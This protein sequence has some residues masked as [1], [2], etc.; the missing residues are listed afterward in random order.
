MNHSLVRLSKIFK[1]IVCFKKT[2][3]YNFY[4]IINDVKNSELIESFYSILNDPSL[5]KCLNYVVA[6]INRNGTSLS[7]DYNVM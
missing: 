5:C 1:F 2:A 3:R 4:V 7:H 6:R